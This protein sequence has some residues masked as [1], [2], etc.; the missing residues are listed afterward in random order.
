MALKLR[1]NDKSVQLTSGQL[2]VG[3]SIECHIVTND[4]LAS[5]RHAVIT[6]SK[7]GAFVSDLGSRAGVQVNGE[8]VIGA[9]RLMLGD[10]IFVSS[11][12][13]VVEDLQVEADDDEPT[14]PRMRSTIT[15]PSGMT[16]AP[17][18]RLAPT[19]PL[20]IPRIPAHK[21]R[22][23]IT[24]LM[25]DDPEALTS[26]QEAPR[27]VRPQEAPRAT[28]PETAPREP[29]MAAPRELSTTGLAAPRE[30][31]I[32]ASREA[33]ISRGPS[34]DSTLRAVAL[35]AEKALALGRADEAER[36]LQRALND[37]LEAARRPEADA[38]SAELSASLAARLAT[39]TGSGR[40]FDASVG[41]YRTRGEVPPAQVIDLLFAAAH[42][43]KAIDK[44]LFREYVAA[45]KTAPGDSPA[46]RFL[47]QRLE[48]LRGIVDL[49]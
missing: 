47:V 39:A 33:P 40:W 17:T 7:A 44:A 45:M 42:K 22:E 37:A 12:R 35:L 34:S 25:E 1:Y 13:I 20:G 19:P 18:V 30:A 11:L 32:T 28:L 5:R 15:P 8:T 48:G 26:T 4:P 41:V 9:R 46:R 24:E 36:I 2:F 27:L 6:M 38:A 31:A 43:V 10:E 14:D 21:L 3:R 49:K 29:S 16:G 23:T